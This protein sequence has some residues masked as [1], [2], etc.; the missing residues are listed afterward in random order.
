MLSPADV[1][2][3]ITRIEWGSMINAAEEARKAPGVADILGAFGEEEGFEVYI[4]SMKICQRAKYEMARRYHEP[5]GEAP[6]E[7]WIEETEEG[8]FRLR[9]GDKRA[10]STDRQ[11]LV[12]KAWDWAME[13]MYEFE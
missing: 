5:K 1:M 2:A 4:E 6:E 3:A 10:R 7:D 12:E 8:D 13:G 11:R 9:V